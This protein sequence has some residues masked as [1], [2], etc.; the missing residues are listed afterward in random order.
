MI[1]RKRP[2]RILAVALSAIYLANVFAVGVS[3]AELEGAAEP[4]PVEE[5][6]TVVEEA[7]APVVEEA[8]A[9]AAEE[10]PAP[11][12]EEAPAPAA[13][14]APAP[15][16]EE[17][18]AP[19]VEETPA[20][21]AEE[22]PAPVVEEAPAPAAE[23]APAPA[24]EEAPAPVVEET[25]APAAEEAPAPAAEETPAPAAE[26]APAPVVEETPAPAAE[27]A[28]APAAEETPA[29]AAEEAP[30]PVV[31]ETPAPA[32][33][34]APVS[35][36]IEA[37][38][39]PAEAGDAS[40]TEEELI[41]LDADS[42]S[43]EDAGLQSEESASAA[44]PEEAAADESPRTVEIQVGEHIITVTGTFPEGT[45][46]QAAAIPADAA[47][48]MS[49]KAALFAYDIRLVVDGQVWQP[50]DHGTQVQV[51]VRNTDGSAYDVETDV[52]HVKSDL[53]DQ[54]GNLS[55]EALE[56]VLQDIS[57]GSA[58]TEKLSADTKDSSYSF[59]A[60]SFS[61]YVGTTNSRIT[62]V[63]NAKL[64]NNGSQ[65]YVGV[66]TTKIRKNTD[67]AETAKTSQTIGIDSIA[68]GNLPVPTT[69]SPAII[70]GAAVGYENRISATEYETIKARP[71]PYSEFTVKIMEEQGADGTVHRKASGF[72]GTYVIVRLDVQEFFSSGSDNIYLHMEQKDNKALMAAATVAK[73]MAGYVKPVNSF[74]DGLGNRSAAYNLKDLVDPGSLSSTPYVDVILYA[75]AANVAGADAGKADAANG[76][77]PLAFYVDDKLQYNDALV[78]YDPTSVSQSSDPNASANYDASWHKKFFD[79]NQSAISHYLV[80]GSDLALE[81]AVEKSDASGSKTT[82]WS[83]K[84]SMEDSYYD[85]P[86][87]SDPNDEGCGRTVKLMSE[88]A[89]TNGLTLQGTDENNLKKRTLDVNSYDIQ[90]ATNTGT[91]GKA[92]ENILVKNAWL[93]IADKSNTTGAEMA[94]GNNAQFVIDQ[95]GKLIIDET[96]Q[97]EIEWDGATTTPAADGSTPPAD[98]LNNGQLDLRAGGEIVNNGIITIEGTEGKPIQSGSPTAQQSIDSQKGSGEM[99]IREGATLTNNGALVI[100]G[101]LKNLGTLVN[102]G[103]FDDVIKSNDP[104]KGAFNYHKGIQVSWKDDVTQKNIVAGMLTNDVGGMLI[105]NGDIV[106]TPGTLDNKGTLINE[107]GANIYSAAA[108]EAIIPITPDPKTPTIVTKRIMLNPVKLSY[109]INSGTL[110]NC[111]DIAPATVTLLD[112]TG[113]FDQLNSPG[114]HPELF[115]FE[116]SG[117]VIELKDIFP[118]NDIP[119]VAA[120][121][122]GEWEVN[123]TWLYLYKDSSFLAEFSDGVR[124]YGTF[125]FEGEK[126]V[127]TFSDETVAVPEADEAGNWTYSITTKNGYSVEFVLSA[128]FVRDARQKME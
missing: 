46:L 106:L 87:D 2:G 92:A 40:E 21:A 22:A 103:R 112:N 75:T 53:L 45:E 104:D 116:N 72:D 94:I 56:K 14:A 20:P 95:G 124:L 26:E 38:S 111:G 96:C 90:V 122:G 15:A 98:I 68:D 1:R 79:P 93:T 9:P 16:A 31:E 84:K 17:V 69:E 109:I 61:S 63:Y 97:L 36:E 41:L 83:L 126:L 123:D 39:D 91:E 33:E 113:A 85:Q 50:E 59:G 47:A 119:L 23:E 28:P 80:K 115:T 42:D 54:A 78:D 32:A 121:S 74:T 25:P 19:V 18:P 48:K 88:V 24:V 64:F 114:D 13:E 67:S 82:Y 100:Y 52:L 3:A 27:E 127:F 101:K 51:S 102:N 11:V 118:I 120:L 105:N 34:E 128:D 117:I 77:I 29:P 6:V 55:E 12:V 7:P 71:A 60:S 8:P 49:G 70:Q 110:I 81:T 107:R 44:D 86:V 89:I 73:G 10:A 30:A 62:Y 58:E 35:A 99:T 66:Y 65:D 43:G 76:D 57:D 125:E 37:V 108:T 4:V 5:V